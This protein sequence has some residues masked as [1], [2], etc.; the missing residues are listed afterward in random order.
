MPFT[1][2]PQGFANGLSVRG[3]P[4]LQAQPGAV[5]FVNNGPV[6][7]GQ[8][9]A[10][11]DGNR[12]TFLDP[13]ATLNYAVN[14]MAVDGRGDIIFVGP[15]HSETISSATILALNTAGVAVIGL[16]AGNLRPTFTFTTAT[17]ANIPVN[18]ANISIQNCLFQ[19]NFLSVASVFTALSASVT[20]SI[21][22]NVL[23][24]TVVGSGVLVP[25]TSVLGT[26]V[27]PGTI[28]LSQISGATTGGVGTYLLNNSQ[29]F[30]SGTITTGPQDFSIDNCEFRDLSNVLSFLS[31]FTSSSTANAAS[32]FSFTRNSIFGL[33]TVA[34]TVALTF[35]AANDRVTVSDN[36]GVSPITAVTQG[37]ALMATG[38]NNITNFDCGRNRFMRP[39][40][41]TTLP[42]GIST[43]GT[44]WTG[45]CYDNYFWS[46]NSG[47]GIWI[48]TG[49]KLGFT[50][51]Y[52]PITGAA[53]KSAL[54]NPV[55]V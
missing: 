31:I 1:N 10:G 14:T 11:S 35:A 20:A 28:I 33:G 40:T 48:N 43:S 44:A 39:N 38:A 30:A 49:T 53:D 32:G 52:S 18:G 45:H 21:A 41:S 6:L 34:P 8:A 25:G 15:G 13:F 17:T 26:G 9:R 50:N 23:T 4:L 36:R 3:V 7:L 37:P 19:A 16:G 46:L 12:G 5:F 47:T 24:V 22:T 55:A 2:F 29:T 42:V 51:N 54:I 27:T